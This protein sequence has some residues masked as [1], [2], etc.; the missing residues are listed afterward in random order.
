M[1]KAPMIRVSK[2]DAAR[3]QLDG[4]VELWF[5][6]GDEVCVHTLAAAAH[7]IIHDINQKKGGG[8][9][10]F[11]SA[12]I[13]EEYRHEWIA[14]LKKSMN[15]FKHANQ[16]AEEVTEFTPL[17]SIMFI[18]FSIIGLQRI[19]ERLND[20]ENAFLDWLAFHHPEWMTERY[21]KVIE[22]R[23]PV[24]HLHEIRA[25]SKSNFFEA[26]IRARTESRYKGRF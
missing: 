17:T 24:D 7:Q 10:L 1:A 12:K 8:E 20:T 6:D 15:F 5:A 21:R 18:M 22:E 11:D 4:A 2:L 23:I 16:D 14:L 3:R 13:K 25:L 9:L 19:G 26:I